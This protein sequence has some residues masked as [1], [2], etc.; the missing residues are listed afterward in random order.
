MA[1]A[2]FSEASVEPCFVGPLARSA[3]A[4]HLLG[5][6]SHAAD[7]L[8]AALGRAQANAAA[9]HSE[10]GR[11]HASAGSGDG[12]AGRTFRAVAFKVRK[13]LASAWTLGGGRGA[14]NDAVSFT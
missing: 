3:V 14:S 13:F 7:P 2:P 5:R 6:H 12:I 10:D 1:A 11:D 8:V 4:P 9:V